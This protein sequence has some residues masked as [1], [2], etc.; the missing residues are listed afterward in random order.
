MHM[1]ARYEMFITIVYVFLSQI[2]ASRGGLSGYGDKFIN[3]II[4]E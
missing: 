3:F 1:N 2:L 4:Y